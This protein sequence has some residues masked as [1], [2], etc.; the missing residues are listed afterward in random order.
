M[1]LE[2]PGSADIPDSIISHFIW[3]GSEEADAEEKL[4]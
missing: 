4:V 3:I 1:K 2:Y